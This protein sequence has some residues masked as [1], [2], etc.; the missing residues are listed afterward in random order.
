M[1]TIIREED[2][3]QN[4]K[5]RVLSVSQ[6]ELISSNAAWLGWV[7]IEALKKGL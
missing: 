5:E 1:M 3:Q 7:K 2:S 4:L 6:E